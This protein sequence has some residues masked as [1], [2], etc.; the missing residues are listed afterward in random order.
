MLTIADSV[1]MA[2]PANGLLALRTQPEN[3]HDA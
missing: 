1:W 2:S 3:P